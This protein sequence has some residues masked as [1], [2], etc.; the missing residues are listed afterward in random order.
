MG[1]VELKR[2]PFCG[3][4]ADSRDGDMPAAYCL[5]DTCG[6]LVYGDDRED[7]ERLWNTRQAL[8]DTS[9]AE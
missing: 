1:E 8:K 6:A 9:N 5:R 3:A 7:A 2:C 4:L